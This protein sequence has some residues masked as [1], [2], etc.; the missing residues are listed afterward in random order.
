MHTRHAVDVLCAAAVPYHTPVDR[1]IVALADLGD[2]VV[3][4]Q[5]V[6]PSSTHLGRVRLRDNAK[7]VLP[8][9]SVHAVLWLGAS[10]AAL[11]VLWCLWRSARRTPRTPRRP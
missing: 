5:V 10:A 11:T 9:V 2:L 1:L 7:V 4:T 6:P 8:D 3:V